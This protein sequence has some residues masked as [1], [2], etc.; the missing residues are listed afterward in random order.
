MEVETSADNASLAA[1]VVSDELLTTEAIA[2][3]K[4]KLPQYIVNCFEAAGYDTLDVI[5]DMDVSDQSGNSLDEIENFIN[6][7][8]PN[9]AYYYRDTSANGPLKF[10]PGHRKRICKFVDGIRSEH[11]AKLVKPASLSGKRP[12]KEDVPV[13]TAKKK[14][15]QP[16]EHP[17]DGVTVRHDQAVIYGNIRRQVVKWQQS[18]KIHELRKLKEH[19]Q[20]E[21]VVVVNEGSDP[22]ASLTC[23][24]CGHRC[25]LGFKKGTVLI[26]NW[27]R[28]V[29]KCINSPKRHQGQGKENMLKYL[30][31][32]SV[33]SLL[34]TFVSSD[35]AVASP[36]SAPQ[37]EH[38]TLAQKETATSTDACSS[39]DTVVIIESTAH[40]EETQTAPEPTEDTTRRVCSFKP[41]APIVVEDAQPTTVSEEPSKKDDHPFQLP[42]PATTSQ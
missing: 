4:A 7:T 5:A 26:S 19:E 30:T 41:T 23:K 18:Q 13:G 42:S 1:M 15:A 25:A 8:F 32:T 39:A 3:M 21:V 16:A 37:N 9:N 29:L 10:P 27:T 20:F 36:S 24:M 34:T 11:R 6:T 28:H 33:S 12:T 38:V 17:E 2:V 35:S 31:N 14:K 40:K 22:N